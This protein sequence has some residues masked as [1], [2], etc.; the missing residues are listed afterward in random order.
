M[1]LNYD[2][3]KKCDCSEFWMGALL[4]VDAVRG[5]EWFLGSCWGSAVMFDSTES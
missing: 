2:Q 1:A 4:C 5:R 3:I